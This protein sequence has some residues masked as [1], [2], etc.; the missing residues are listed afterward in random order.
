MSPAINL[1]LNYSPPTASVLWTGPQNF[2]SILP[3]P[4]VSEPGTYT[5]VVT[6]ANGCTAEAVV[7][8]GLDT[9]SPQL[10]ASGGL[11]TC[12]QNQV[13]LSASVMPANSA[14]SWTGPQN[15]SSQELSP[16]VSVP[17]IYTLVATSPNGCTGATQV[18][19]NADTDFPQVSIQGGTLNCVQTSLTLM[20]A[21]SPA[22]SILAWSGPQ[23]FS[24]S[25]P[26]PLI[27]I[28]GA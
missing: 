20:S 21:V 10:S 1:Q 4:A 7:V 18:Q 8:I 2:N 3:N 26:N 19:V 9:M 13:M 22:Q 25:Q 28:P 15:Y 5:V 24:S 12:L 17:G 27:N 23:N 6:G 14:V 16:I 11:L